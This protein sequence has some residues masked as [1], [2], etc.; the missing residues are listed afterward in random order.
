MDLSNTTFFKLAITFVQKHKKHNKKNF[1]Y[2]THCQQKNFD[3][4]K[5]TWKFIKLLRA[6]QL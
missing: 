3:L 1:L 4:I 2:W 6:L 5:N